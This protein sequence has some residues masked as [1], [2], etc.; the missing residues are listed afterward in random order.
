MS[1]TE[2]APQV[3][4]RRVEFSHSTSES[5]YA[6]HTVF[7]QL[8]LT[9]FLMKLLF[10]AQCVCHNVVL[11]VCLEYC[12]RSRVHA[13]DENDLSLPTKMHANEYATAGLRDVH[14]SKLAC[15]RSAFLVST[16]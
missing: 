4:R 15:L 10:E 13:A 3:E 2:G 8:L 14:V 16:T 11:T 1:A 5:V 9:E 12:N 7:I 6:F